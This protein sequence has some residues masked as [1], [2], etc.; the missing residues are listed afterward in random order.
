MIK[1]LNAFILAAGYGERLR[2]ITNHIPKPLL[3]ILGKPLLES[4][5]EKIFALKSDKIGTGWIGI[6][7]H[8]KKDDIEAWAKGCRFREKIAL[9]AEEPILDTGGALKNAEAFL[10]GRD[11]IVHNG[12]II[13]DIDLAALAEYHL[14]SG[15]M[16]TLAVHDYPRFNNVIIGG[17]GYLRGI[18][19]DCKSGDSSEKLVAFTGIAVYSAAFLEFLPPGVSSVVDAWMKA[20]ASGNRVGTFDAAGCTWSD[21]GSPGAY[22]SAV[23]RELQRKGEIAHIDPST[24]GCDVSELDGTIVIEKGCT[25][26][27]SSS[28]RN[29]IVLPGCR[30]ENGSVLEDCVAGPDYIV[31]VDESAFVTSTV[32]GVLVGTGGS[33]RKYFRVPRKGGTAILMECH[34]EDPDFSRHIEYTRFF[35]KYGVP[36]PAIFDVEPE[37]KSALF[38]D[39]GDFSLYSWLKCPR[40][41]DEIEKAYRLVLDI[42]VQLHG[43]AS[44]HAAECPMLSGRIFDYD[45][46]RWETGY[47]SD[48]F[49]RGLRRLKIDCAELLEDEFH[50]LALK[51]DAYT[52]RIIHRDFQ[53]QNIMMTKGAVPRVIDYQGA[54]MAPPAYDI[55]SVLFDPYAPLQEDLRERLLAYYSKKMVVAASA[56]FSEEE[57]FESLLY[58]KL[59]RHM[60]A[61]GAYGFLSEV[62]GKTY[63]LNHVPECLRLLKE[64]TE[65][66]KKE[67][68][69]LYNLAVQL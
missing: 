55:A 18:G 61:L 68:P 47:F 31:P 34:P 19:K 13:S 10:A 39:L 27:R 44:D 12:D 62:K 8:H 58:C 60:Q 7:V 25:I 9:F 4:I 22:V 63:F 33:D 54:R 57:F 11:F 23:V 1:C 51:A 64:E 17:D 3:P 21:I 36:V 59:Q 29:C 6:N 69:A 46:L 42:L 30:I 56:W 50:R 43:E 24:C 45:Y 65:K 49:V 67:F 28:L 32:K 2:P 41:N 37:K 14:R 40:R 52:K 66:A 20:S 35:A 48:R 26:G 53:S 15:N 5:V 16:V 38:E